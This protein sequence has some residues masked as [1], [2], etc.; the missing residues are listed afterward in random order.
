[1]RSTGHSGNCQS[2]LKYDTMCIL[3][4]SSVTCWERT[5]GRQGGTGWDVREPTRSQRGKQ[6]IWLR[7]KRAW[8]D[9]GGLEDRTDGA[10]SMTAV[11]GYGLRNGGWA[12]FVGEQGSQRRSRSGLGGGGEERRGESWRQELQVKVVRGPKR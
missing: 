4:N 9:L 6:Q 8:E 11:W 2:F 1:M 5:G 10:L 7:K 3:S 12:S